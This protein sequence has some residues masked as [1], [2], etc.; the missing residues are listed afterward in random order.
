MTAT[1]R[2]IQAKYGITDLAEAADSLCSGMT[3]DRDSAAQKLADRVLKRKSGGGD[4][5]G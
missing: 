1:M 3:P 2:Q 5:H 4:V